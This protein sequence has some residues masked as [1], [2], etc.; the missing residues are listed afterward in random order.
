MLQSIKIVQWLCH[1]RGICGESLVVSVFLEVTLKDHPYIIFPRGFS[2]HSSR[3]EVHVVISTAPHW[4]VL[5]GC[6]IHISSSMAGGRSPLDGELPC[7]ERA[8]GTSFPWALS[9][10]CTGDLGSPTVVPALWWGWG[11]A[12]ES[13][14]PFQSPWALVS[15]CTLLAESAVMCVCGSICSVLSCAWP[16]NSVCSGAAQ[17]FHIV[18]SWKNL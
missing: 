14:A 3:C 4:R 10:P 12:L 5:H 9:K 17:L 7:L 8:G 1:Q 6:T 16:E 18:V 15:S 11:M 2:T 13:L